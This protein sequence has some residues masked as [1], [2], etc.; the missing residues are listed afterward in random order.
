MVE[1]GTEILNVVSSTPAVTL[2]IFLPVL[3]LNWDKHKEHETLF[4]WWTP[5]QVWKDCRQ[6]RDS[7]AVGLVYR[8]Q[9]ISPSMGNPH[10]WNILQNQN[11]FKKQLF[12]SKS[13]LIPQKW[14]YISGFFVAA[15]R[16][17]L[18]RMQSTVTALQSADY[19]TEGL[20]SP[21]SA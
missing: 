4:S 18:A 3:L 20:E 8:K 16:T 6:S 10:T 13:D 15:P 12:Q 1:H 21:L 19:K 17:S 2:A 11:H 14:I 7:L 9:L 5:E